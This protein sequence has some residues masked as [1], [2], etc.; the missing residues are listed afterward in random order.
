[1]R[2]VLRRGFTLVE[3]LIVIGIV[4]LLLAILLPVLNKARQQAQQV[5][6]AS[7]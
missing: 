7:N 2:H 5:Q 1:M 6:C 4:L 3:L